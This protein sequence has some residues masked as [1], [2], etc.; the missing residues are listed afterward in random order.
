MSDLYEHIKALMLEVPQF[1]MLSNEELDTLSHHV[2]HRRVPK[3]MVLCREG[4]VGDSLFYIVEGRIEIKKESFD[5]RQTVLAHFGKGS[6]VG[7]MSLVEES[8][9]S[10]TAT[11]I[12]DTELLIL[13]RENFE[14]ML[15]D[16]PS[17]GVKVLRNIAK[18]LSTRLR[19]TSGRFADVF[20]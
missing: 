19:H 1:D 3:G 20:K 13:S 10:A 5:G 17:I 12:E 4:A 2:F 8:A 6:T 15:A 9:R 7:E 14:R 11:A 16:Q 18:S